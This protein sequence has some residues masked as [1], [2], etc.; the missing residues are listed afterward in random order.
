METRKRMSG[1]LKGGLYKVYISPDSVKYYSLNKAISEG[2]FQ[3]QA[4]TDGR[5]TRRKK[6]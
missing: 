4:S 3:G 6:K 2:G 1:K 5:R